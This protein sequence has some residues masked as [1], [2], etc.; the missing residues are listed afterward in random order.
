MTSLSLVELFLSNHIHCRFQSWFINTFNSLWVRGMK[1]SAQERRWHISPEIKHFCMWNSDAWCGAHKHGSKHIIFT[2]NYWRLIL[3]KQ[4][5][6]F[7]VDYSYISKCVQGFYQA[8]DWEG[9]SQP[10][11]CKQTISNKQAGLLSVINSLFTYCYMLLIIL[12][13]SV[14]DSRMERILTCEPRTSSTNYV[15]Q[16]K[17]KISQVNINK[18]STSSKPL[19]F[20]TRE[21]QPWCTGAPQ[22]FY[23]IYIAL[24]KLGTMLHTQLF[25]LNSPP[26]AQGRRG[27]HLLWTPATSSSFLRHLNRFSSHYCKTRHWLFPFIHPKI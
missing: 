16:T 21:T 23:C 10:A 9:K 2:G 4:P 6:I 13:M 3:R 17:V 24:G 8:R 5:K 18:Q 7:L 26:G 19:S 22:H 25:L 11:R 27:T 20:F 15:R 1:H 12:K 14:K